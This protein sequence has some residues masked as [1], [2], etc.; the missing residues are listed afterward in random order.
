M[1]A[2]RS[3]LGTV[4][5]NL[6]MGVIDVDVRQ[7]LQRSHLVLRQRTLAADVQNRALGAERGGDAGHRIGAARARRS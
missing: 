4:A 2:T 6:V 1:S 5:A 7:I 3:V